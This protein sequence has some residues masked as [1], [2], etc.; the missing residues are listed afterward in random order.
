MEGNE[1]L[2]YVS[3]GE[4]LFQF[5][6]NFLLNFLPRFQLRKRNKNNNCFA[7]GTNIE[8]AGTLNLF[9]LPLVGD[10]FLYESFI[11]LDV[12]ITATNYSI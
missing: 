5:T 7:A 12:A 2:D 1:L 11:N 10:N 9:L 6:N 3:I 4:F 8:L